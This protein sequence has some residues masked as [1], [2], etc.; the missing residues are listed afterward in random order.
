MFV[1]DLV[2][3]YGYTHDKLTHFN[4]LIFN[5]IT[6]DWITIKNPTADEYI[7]LCDRVVID[8]MVEENETVDVTVYSQPNDFEVFNKYLRSK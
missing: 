7:H 4:I 5:P 2:K 6:G 8:W 3:T 1:N